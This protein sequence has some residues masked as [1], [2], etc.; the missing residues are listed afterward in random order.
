MKAYTL[1]PH[2]LIHGDG[3]LVDPP[4]GAVSIIDPPYEMPISRWLPMVRDPSIVFGTLRMMLH[5]PRNLWRFERVWVKR[6]SHRSATVAIGHQHAI[7]A[8]IGAVK[9]LPKR[10]TFPSVVY[11]R[12]YPGLVR[13]EKPYALLAEHLSAW[14]PPGPVFDPF[15]GSGSSIIAADVCGRACVAVERDE[16]KCDLILERWAKHVGR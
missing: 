9:T 2:T 5:L 14:T 16:S 11:E 8:Q 1:G 6:R 7:I 10:G 3:T 15:A 13:Y 12:D 4:P